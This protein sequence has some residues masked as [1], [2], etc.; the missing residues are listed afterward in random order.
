MGLAQEGVQCAVGWLEQC[1][2]NGNLRANS[3][4]SAV[5]SSCRDSSVCVFISGSAMVENASPV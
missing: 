5:S 4:A 1:V 3:Y 2:T